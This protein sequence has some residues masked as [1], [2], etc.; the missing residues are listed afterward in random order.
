MSPRDAILR[1][2]LDA[3]PEQQAPV[4]APSYADM[5]CATVE[6]APVG[7]AAPPLAAHL[8][9][10]SDDRLDL[11]LR[12]SQLD[13]RLAS[14][15]SAVS[16]EIL[17]GA[18][19]RGDGAAPPTVDPHAAVLDWLVGQG[20]MS[21]QERRGHQAVGQSVHDL[22][23]RMNPA[24]SFE[25]A[26]LIAQHEVRDLAWGVSQQ[27]FGAHRAVVRDG[28]ARIAYVDPSSS[29]GDL[30]VFFGVVDEQYHFWVRIDAAEVTPHIAF[31][32]YCPAYRAELVVHSP[33]VTSDA[34][35]CHLGLQPTA[36][37][38]K[39]CPILSGPRV[40]PAHQWRLEAMPGLPGFLDQKLDTLLA[41]VRDSTE[42]F[43][44]LPSSCRVELSV[45]SRQWQAWP[46][47]VHLSPA[48]IAALANIGAAFDLD[49]Y[50]SGPPEAAT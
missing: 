23:P 30:F 28:V 29:P 22:A 17:A 4:P 46:E 21:N 27:F 35:T 26:L 36:V 9:T 16:D 42:R 19:S 24:G 44:T 48:Y 25:T 7:G 8:R 12:L 43:A 38:A 10:D 33:D 49:L 39:G 34:L 50:A 41:L 18:I 6:V 31:V 13:P 11:A 2:L 32:G 15:L 20:L 1:C 45:V 47:G 40:Y 14:R 3:L 37:R 5:S